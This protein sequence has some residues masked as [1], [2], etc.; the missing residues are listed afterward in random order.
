MK[1]VGKFPASKFPGVLEH[2]FKVINF[3]LKIQQ[4]HETKMW[5]LK[6]NYSERVGVPVEDLVFNFCGDEVS[7]G[8]YLSIFNKF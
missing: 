8:K 7:R 4:K 1:V 5:R 3:R 2:D 6:K